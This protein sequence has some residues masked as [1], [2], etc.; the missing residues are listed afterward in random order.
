MVGDRKKDREQK[1]REEESRSGKREVERE[2]EKTVDVQREC[3]D[4][5][6]S[7][8]FGCV[9]AVSSGVPVV[10]DEALLSGSDG[11]NVEP[12]SFFSLQR[13]SSVKKT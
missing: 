11:E 10:T 3:V 9:P 8:V 13:A 4:N 5:F 6:S 7:D 1:L 12:H 2:E